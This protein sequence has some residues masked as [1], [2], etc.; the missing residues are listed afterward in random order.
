MRKK[1]IAFA[2]SN[3]TQSINRSLVAKT[4]KSF[5]EY[6]IEFLDLNDFEM[7]IYSTDREQKDGISEKAH[8]FRK[9]MFDCDAII[10]SFAEHNGNF[11]VAFKNI[12][13]WCSR[14][15]MNV[16]AGKPMFMMST[17]PSKFGGKFVM[18]IAQK[19]LPFYGANIVETFSLPF[20]Y[21]NLI[22][23]EIVDEAL[24]AEYSE[25]VESFKK[26]LLK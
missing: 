9:H 23:N 14:I 5:A 26:L 12:F 24:K 7:P 3:S 6:D 21:Q 20:Y 18:E 8:Q 2:G 16:F 25:K 13:D 11:T 4:L 1:I 15:D 22:D 10:C 17:S 19:S